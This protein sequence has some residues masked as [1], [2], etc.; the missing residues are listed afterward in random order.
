MHGASGMTRVNRSGPSSVNADRR[1]G[2]VMRCAVVVGLC[3]SSAIGL[4]GCSA[5]D[6]GVELNGK[7][8]DAV[9]LSGTGKKKSEPK[10]AERAPLVPPSRVDVLPAPGETQTAAAHMAWPNDPDKRRAAE[11]RQAKQVLDK[12]CSDPMLGRPEHE[13]TERD[14]KCAEAKGGLLSMATSWMTGKSSQGEAAG[15]T[16][17]EGD[18]SGSAI[19]TGSTTAPV[20]GKSSGGARRTQ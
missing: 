17:D 16:S 2:M 12:E 19:V 10:L 8:F 3:V 6:T 13:R 20:A 9:G 11:A 18:P 7:I 1:A 4:T 15:T 5:G 14:A